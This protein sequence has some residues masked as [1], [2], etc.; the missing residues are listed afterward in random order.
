M[1]ILIHSRQIPVTGVTSLESR[2][3]CNANVVLL[4]ALRG[5]ENNS[6]SFLCV[7]YF[8]YI[9]SFIPHRSQNIVMTCTF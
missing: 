7:G 9:I 6:N 1:F 2:E 3:V 4:P 8:S 5:D